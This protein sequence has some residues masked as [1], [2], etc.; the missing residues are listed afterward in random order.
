M[1]PRPAPSIRR[2]GPVQDGPKRDV[3]LENPVPWRAT[4]DLVQRHVNGTARQEAEE[5]V[6]V[7]IE[8][9]SGPCQVCGSDNVVKIR[10]SEDDS[11]LW[12]AV[13]ADCDEHVWSL[14]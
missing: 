12:V 10:V 1:R 14:G 2:I 5:V 4:I 6:V 13:C 7:H 3:E 8:R 11:P 9:R